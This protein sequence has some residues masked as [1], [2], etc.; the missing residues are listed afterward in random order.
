MKNNTYFI[1]P[2][3]KDKPIKVV[4]EDKV[5]ITSNGNVVEIKKHLSS[6]E[7]EK[8]LNNTFGTTDIGVLDCS[9]INI[10][11]YTYYCP[12]CKRILDLTEI[13]SCMNAPNEIVD[14]C[15]V[16]KSRVINLNDEYIKSK[17]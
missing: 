15:L 10:D 12:T 13:D 1:I 11:R 6:M 4:I 3:Q 2:E 7:V 17:F 5:K 9:R 8:L 14:Y 16:C